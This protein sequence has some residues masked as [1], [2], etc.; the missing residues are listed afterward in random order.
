MLNVI[1]KKHLTAE[2]I[3]QIIYSVNDTLDHS[4]GGMDAI[5]NFAKSCNSENFMIQML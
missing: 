1:A 5:I 4:Q 2:E 3:V